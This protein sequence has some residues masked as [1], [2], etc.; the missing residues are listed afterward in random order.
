MLALKRI[1]AG[2]HA[3][4]TLVFDEVDSGIGGRV[5]AVLGRKL[6]DIASHHQ[7][8][9][10][11]HLAPVAAFAHHH[12]VVEK[13]EVGGRTVVRTRYLEDEQ[14]VEE[15]A[16]MMGGIEVSSGIIRSARE[17]LE[18]ARG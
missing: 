11:T 12:I 10:I 18:E 7:V 3:V 4:P 14:R 17:L 8:L 16:R 6:K 13:D 2:A 9:C 5:A 1:M 15:L